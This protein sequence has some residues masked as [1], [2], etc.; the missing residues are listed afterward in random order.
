MLHTRLHWFLLL[1]ICFLPLAGLLAEDEKD[2]PAPDAPE[3]V[4]PADRPGT[5]APPADVVPVDD[6]GNWTA[7]E[8][9]DDAPLTPEEQKEQAYDD[10]AVLT[11]ALMHV[12]KHYVVEH[13]YE[14]IL[15]GALDGMLHSLDPHS[16]FLAPRA[17]NSMRE[18]TAG[19]FCG[20]G[21]H[22]GMREG[23]LTVIAPIEDSPAY[24]AGLQA[25]DHIIKIEGRRTTGI[26]LQGAVKVLRG[27]R[28]EAV[29]VTVLR[30]PEDP[31]DV[32]IVR[33]NIK[34]SS[35][36]GVRIL[37]DEIGYI[38]ITQF[39]DPTVGNFAKALRRLKEEGMT[40][41][42]LDLRNN[43]GGLLRSAI[44]ISSTLLKHKSV[45]VSTRGRDAETDID[46]HHANGR[47]HLTEMPV[48]VLVNGG[49]ASASEIVAGAL[50]DHR[51]A[52]IIGQQ[53]FGKASVQS[54]VRLKS[55]PDCAIRMTTAHYYTPEGRMIHGEGIEPDIV[56]ELTPR[57]WRK[58][59]IRRAYEETPDAWPEEKRE[60]LQ[61]VQDLQL[62]RAL[63]AITAVRV[64][65]SGS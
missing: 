18:D 12:R 41:L 39:N 1:S 25:G 49:S 13:S 34:V 53:S 17:Y 26:T 16:S 62:Q 4:E 64:V 42:V 33:D 28:G 43:P 50:Q 2:A 15:F 55:N 38:R 48:A 51:R 14:E 37:R 35:I 29:T 8:D 58:V 60:D 27:R 46:I 10:M 47:L 30:P 44:G 36:K 7:E 20:I 54:I 11:E 9:G 23:L 63:D 57:E 5:N 21:I 59:Q 56:V 52:V 6:K 24:R 32:S 65:T 3:A 45:V 22:V 61:D 19:E 31:F 40:A